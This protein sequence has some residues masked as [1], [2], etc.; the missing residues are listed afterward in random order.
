FYF[1]QNDVA[2]TAGPTTLTA[3]IAAN[4][5]FVPDALKPILASRKNPTAPFTFSQ[6][7]GEFGMRAFSYR[8]STF[9]LLTGAKGG[10]DLFG[11]RWNWDVYGSYGTTTDI[12][13]TS[14]STDQNVVNLLTL[15]ADGGASQGC[16]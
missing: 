9:Q 13:G 12:F 16:A 14:A 3:Q 6:T 4:N 7:A 5:P 2:T 15:A 8:Y 1:A 10:F 11:S